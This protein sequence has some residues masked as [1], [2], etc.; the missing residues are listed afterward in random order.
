[1]LPVLSPGWLRRG[2]LFLSPFSPKARASHA[3]AP[4]PQLE[5]PSLPK[6]VQGQSGTSREKG[7]L[8]PPE[9]P[10]RLFLTDWADFRWPA[11]EFGFPLLGSLEFAVMK[12]LP[13]QKKAKSLP[14]MFLSLVLSFRWYTR[15]IFRPLFIT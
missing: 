10:V 2:H 8:N 12:P 14:G 9:T 13:C 3:P 5:P 1:M 6:E 11:S 15:H 7:F 4:Q